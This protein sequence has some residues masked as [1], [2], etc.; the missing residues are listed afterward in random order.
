MRYD[1]SCRKCIY[2]LT[3]SVNR[4][5]LCRI[6]GVVSQ[7]FT[8]SKYKVVSTARGIHTQK[9]KC[10]ECEFYITDAANSLEPI[11]IGFCQ[12]FTVRKFNGGMKNACSKFTLKS[13]SII[14]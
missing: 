2:G 10:M 11:T 5:I 14:S 3:N 4:D 9:N 1:G 12:L 7:D 8:C 13:E 6:K